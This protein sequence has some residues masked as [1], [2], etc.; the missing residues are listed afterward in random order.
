MICDAI[1]FTLSTNANVLLLEIQLKLAG[2]AS[3]SSP[4][5]SL[6]MLILKVENKIGKIEIPG[7]K[8]DND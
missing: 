2:T 5:S 1:V 3:G 8:F 6:R 4:D 7:M